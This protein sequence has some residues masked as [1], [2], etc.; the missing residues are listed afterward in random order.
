LQL[1]RLAL[2]YA[3]PDA[4]NPLGGR[5]FQDR[6]TQLTRAQREDTAFGLDT[7]AEKMFQATQSGWIPPEPPKKPRGSGRGSRRARA[8]VRG[9]RPNTNVGSGRLY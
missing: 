2:D 7:G 4:T 6:A 9:R 1:G 5:R 3:P 8:A